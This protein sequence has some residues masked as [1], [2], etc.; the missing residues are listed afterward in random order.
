MNLPQMNTVTLTIGGRD[1]T[2][3]CGDGEEAQL[4]KLGQIIDDKLQS[5]ATGQGLSE[6]R[7]LLFAALMLA[8]ELQDLRATPHALDA[9]ADRLENLANQ[10]ETDSTTFAQPSC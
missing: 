10:L 7:G 5:M 2:L 9:L 1:Y 8:D 4:Q 3:A 6:S